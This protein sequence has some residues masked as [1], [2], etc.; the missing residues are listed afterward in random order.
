MVA[1]DAAGFA[2]DELDETRVFTAAVIVGCGGEIDGALGRSDCCE[3]DQ[4]VLGFGD[5]FLSENKDVIL[6]ER[7][8]GFFGGGEEDA[9]EIIARADFGDVADGED[10]DWA[11]FGHGAS[12]ILTMSERFTR[13]STENAERGRKKEAR[14]LA[15]P[16]PCFECVVRD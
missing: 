4:A 7:E 2:E 9:G 10:L 13:E 16:L 12:C 15:V 6:L 11:G 1:D 14:R 3:I 8:S 5:D